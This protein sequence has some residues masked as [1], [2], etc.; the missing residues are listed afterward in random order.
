MSETQG[1]QEGLW[2]T[3]LDFLYRTGEIAVP[4]D[5]HG[6]CDKVNEMLD[7][8][9]SGIV[10][11]IVDYSINSASEAQ[12]KVECSDETLEKLFTMWLE[13][14]NINVNGVPTGLQELAKEYYK[15]RWAGSSLCLLKVGKWVAIKA[16]SI[17]IKVPTVLWFV[18]G[19]SVYIKRGDA[20]NYK[21]GSDE[22]YLDE[23]F[24]VNAINGIKENMIVQKPFSRWFTQYPAPY[25]IRKGVYKNWRAMEVLQHKGDE[26][27]SKVL[28]YLFLIEKGTENMFLQKEVDYSDAELKQLVTNFKEAMQRYENEKGKTP[29]A[30]VPFDQKYSHLIP[31]LRNILSEE[32]Y[33]QGYRAI[34]AGLGFVTVVQGV[35]DT[36]KEEVTNPKPFVAEINSG[37]DGF[38]SMLLDVVRL[39]IDEN[40]IDHRKLF[41]ENKSLKISNSPLK[42]NVQGILDQIRSAY[43]YGTIS[44]KTYQEILGIEPEQE[45]ERMR[46]EWDDGLRDLY[47]PH[48]IQNQEQYPDSVVPV[49]KKQNEKQQE[50]EKQPEH[51]QE[52]AK[53]QK[54]LVVCQSCNTSVEIATNLEPSIYIEC[55]KC[56]KILNQEGKVIASK[57]DLEIAPYTM[58]NVPKAIKKLPKDLQ[59]LWIKTFNEVLKKSGDESKAHRISW[60]VVNKER[61]KTSKANKLNTELQKEKLEVTKKQN[62]LL[63]KLINNDK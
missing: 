56:H 58:K 19:S 28:P 3:F 31:D 34:L 42:V 11:T 47:Y 26:V 13:R 46:K 17:T 37:V 53:L 41:S 15:E 59:E 44:V 6:R 14:V 49:S 43:V 9:I 39:I 24:K 57:P 33:R 52:E 20:K 36:R 25:L 10:S 16:D 22:Y 62:K 27:I 2:Q 60:Y 12:F 63:D 29:T 21:L 45:I 40:K 4:G 18:N 51:M 30:A 48:L 50:K 55:S 54:K 32:L 23:F 35:G 7:N 38:K 8:D 5:F 61:N 1:F